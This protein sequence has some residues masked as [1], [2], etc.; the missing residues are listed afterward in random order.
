[1]I[2]L[3]SSLAVGNLSLL[4]ACLWAVAVV[5]F[6]HW[7]M[8]CRRI[9]FVPLTRTKV[10]RVSGF[11][12]SNLNL[13]AKCKPESCLDK[14]RKC[15]RDTERGRDRKRGGEREERRR[16]RERDTARQRGRVWEQE[17]SRMRTTKGA[18]LS[19]CAKRYGNKKSK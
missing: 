18:T 3:S 7:F 12:S 17:R 19:K 8:G 14:Q 2:L 1:M 9:I 11:V 16:G 6:L 4:A 5:A 15:Q 10:S 13:N